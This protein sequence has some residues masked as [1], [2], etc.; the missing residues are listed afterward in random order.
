MR[1][2]KK[3]KKVASISHSITLELIVKVCLT[4]KKKKK[5]KKVQKAQ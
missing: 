3:K 5:Y 2:G 4:F 1:K